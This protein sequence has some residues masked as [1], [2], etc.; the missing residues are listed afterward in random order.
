MCTY[1]HINV[2]N[3]YF[4]LMVLNLFVG[5]S[6][7]KDFFF[8]KPEVEKLFKEAVLSQTYNSKY[9]SKLKSFALRIIA[10]CKPM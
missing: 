8:R 4:T 5:S 3:A 7:M 10:L 1:F 9:N 2:Y 6:E